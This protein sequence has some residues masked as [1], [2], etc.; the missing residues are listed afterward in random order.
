MISAAFESANAAKE[1]DDPLVNYH[2]AGRLFDKAEMSVL[3]PL[4][5]Y[6]LPLIH[7]FLSPLPIETTKPSNTTSEQRSLPIL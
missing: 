7:L 4:L 3:L 2:L 5:S 1:S 6:G